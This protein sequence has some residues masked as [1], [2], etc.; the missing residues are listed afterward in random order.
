MEAAIRGPTVNYGDCPEWNRLFRLYIAAIYELLSVEVGEVPD[1][2]RTV[3]ES[4][5]E[6]EHRS[7]LAKKDRAKQEFIA[8]IRS[9]INCAGE[10][11]S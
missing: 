8:H 11:A 6:Y 5:F 2:T 1:R 4:P 10:T 3:T 7:A 9:H